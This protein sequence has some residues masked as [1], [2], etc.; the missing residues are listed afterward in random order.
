MGAAVVVALIGLAGFMR[1]LKRNRTY[2]PLASFVM[3]LAALMYIVLNA[4]LLLSD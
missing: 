4:S 3:F 1:G 2:F